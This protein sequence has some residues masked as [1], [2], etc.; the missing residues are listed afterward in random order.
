MFEPI[1]LDVGRWQIVESTTYLFIVKIFKHFF[2]QDR[3]GGG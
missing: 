1:G 3:K 2:G